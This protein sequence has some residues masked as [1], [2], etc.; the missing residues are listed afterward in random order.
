[1]LI[2]TDGASRGK[3]VGILFRGDKDDSCSFIG[4]SGFL[5]SRIGFG[6]GISSSFLGSTEIGGIDFVGSI[7]VGF[8]LIIPLALMLIFIPPVSRSSHD[9]FSVGP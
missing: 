3:V 5:S 8:E 6:V 1:M 4:G 9:F 7:G 2:S